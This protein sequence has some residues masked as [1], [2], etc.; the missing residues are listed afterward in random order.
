MCSTSAARSSRR[1]VP[2]TPATRRPGGMSAFSGTSAPAAMGD[3][4]PMRA[5]LRMVA[6]I[7]T[8]T[9]SSTVQPCRTAPW[10]TETP[11]PTWTGNPASVWTTTLSWRLLRAPIRMASQSARRTAPYQTLTS[12]PSSTSATRTTPGAV[13]AVSW[14]TGLCP[15]SVM[16]NERLLWSC[17][18]AVA[19][20]QG[21]S[22]RPGTGAAAH[23]TSRPWLS[24]VPPPQYCAD[25]PTQPY[26]TVTP[27][28]GKAVRLLT[29]HHG[30]GFVL[31]NAWDAGSAR[32]LEALG[33]P[34]I[35]TTSSGI[36]WSHG[37]PDGESLDR[38]TMLEHIA[39]I[40]EMVGVPVSADLEAGYGPSPDDVAR[41]VSGAAGVGAVGANLEDVRDGELLDLEHAVERVAAA[42][43]VAPHG[44]FVLNAR[45]DT[46]L[47]GTG[48]DVFAA[49]VERAQRFVAAGAD[50]VFVPGVVEEE[51]IRRLAAEIPPPLSVVAGLAST[52]DAPTLF[53]LGVKRV[54]VGGSIARAALSVVERA[55]REL[56][57]TGTLG[58]LDGAASYGDLQGWFE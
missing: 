20:R 4:A 24:S 41:T 56:L 57:E 47:L 42:R 21:Q 54:S 10:P 35:A 11:V 37:L 2:G 55:G 44:T 19:A 38:E 5:P 31:P 45:T 36:A 34:A 1:A 48:E 58:F 15:S 7:P 51:T 52:T 26:G 23:R 22:A 27:R 14:T 40:V 53:S 50:C 16:C 32:I 13:Q 6:P 28:P 49:T 46:Y 12:S 29:L 25:V 30:P 8:R 18:D 9:S 33:F 43:S 39:G 17:A 3:P